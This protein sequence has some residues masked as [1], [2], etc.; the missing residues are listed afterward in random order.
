[1]E[2][3]KKQSQKSKHA[4]LATLERLATGPRWRHAITSILASPYQR[5]HQEKPRL[6]VALAIA[7]LVAGCIGGVLLY[8]NTLANNRLNK[9][10]QYNTLTP[11]ETPVEQLGGWQRISP[12]GKD[13]VFAYVDTIEGVSV[14]VS[15][16]PLPVAMQVDTDSK[17]AEIAKRLNATT[18]IAAGETRVY[19]GISAKGPQSVVFTK[20]GLLIFIKSQKKI[21]DIAWAQYIKSLQ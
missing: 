11:T 5:L 1:M 10:P 2:V 20:N 12:P 14:S 7:L 18:V 6:A 4:T 17:V 16:E 9:S 8:R 19:I 13:P 15:Q 21:T 3:T